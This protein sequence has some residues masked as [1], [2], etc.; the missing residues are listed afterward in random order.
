MKESIRR[1]SSGVPRGVDHKPR[2]VPTG[3]PVSHEHIRDYTHLI[4]P[5]HEGHP[6]NKSHDTQLKVK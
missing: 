1:R 6:Y 3:V 2:A 5:A 4:G